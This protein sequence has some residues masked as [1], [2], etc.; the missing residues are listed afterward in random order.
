MQPFQAKPNL[1]G[2]KINANHFNCYPL[3]LSYVFAD[4]IFKQIT[5]ADF[6]YMK[7]SRATGEVN[8]RPILYDFTHNPSYNI[9][10]MNLRN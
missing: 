5:I 6:T 4:F 2:L 1:S 9:A 10:H 8:E 3:A 7:Q